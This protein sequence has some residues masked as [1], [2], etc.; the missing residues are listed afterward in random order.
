MSCLN[1]FVGAKKVTMAENYGVTI[2]G[3]GHIL[4]RPLSFEE[5]ED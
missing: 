3:G 1:E 5:E 2:V 4:V